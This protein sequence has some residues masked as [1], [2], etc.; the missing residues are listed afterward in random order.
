MRVPDILS[1][2]S[3]VSQSLLRREDVGTTIETTISEGPTTHTVVG[4]E[5]ATSSGTYIPTNFHSMVPSAA[6][7]EIQPTTSF[8]QVSSNEIN[9][10]G[11]SCVTIPPYEYYHIGNLTITGCGLNPS[12]TFASDRNI[13]YCTTLRSMNCRDNRELPI[14][15]NAYMNNITHTGVPSELVTHFSCAEKLNSATPLPS[16][17]DIVRYAA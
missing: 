2:V 14:T 15:L 5:S 16:S 11:P 12:G 17:S 9:S 10:D 13:A 6:S 3:V 1:S 4:R 7:T 8:I